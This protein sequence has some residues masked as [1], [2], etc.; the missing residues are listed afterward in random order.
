MI[1][2]IACIV[3]DWGTTNLRVWAMGADG[4]MLAQRSSSRGLLAVEGGRFAD[5]LQ[6][7]CG[8][9]FAGDRQLPVIM[10]GM[11]GSKSGWK[12]V[13]YLAAPIALDRLAQH[14]CRVETPL[15][16]RVWI[17]PG[18]RLDDPDQPDVMRGE[19]TQI[20]GALQALGVSDGVFLLPGT[21]SKWAIVE[22]GALVAFRTYMTGEFFGLL[23]RSGTLSQ[24]MEGDATNGE[25][26]RQGVL[27]ARSPDAGNLLH[28]LFSV[29]TLGLLG[30][31]SP[32][33]LPS[34]MSGLL[35]GAE[36]Q[37]AVLWLRARGKSQIAVGIGTPGIVEAYRGAALLCDFELNTL[38]SAIVVPQGFLSIAV[39]AGVLRSSV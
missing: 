24:L 29:R 36:M 34:Y 39:S 32:L 6:E 21:H 9:W 20:L 12:E 23:R 26:F 1:Q 15:P 19:E 18:V 8:E 31:V 14:L 3:A 11:V 33:G 28:S 27:R 2:A 38:D 5:A 10:C 30:R 37:D 22:A 13:P 16:A 4:R 25:A 35:I 7:A 17:V